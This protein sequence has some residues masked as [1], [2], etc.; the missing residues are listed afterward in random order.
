MFARSSAIAATALAA[1]LALSAPVHAQNSLRDTLQGRSYADGRRPQYPPVGRYVAAQGEGFV[2]DRSNGAPLLKFEDRQEVWAL[3]AHAGARGDIIYKNDVGQPMVRS[4]RLGGLTLFTP[5]RPIG[6]PV[7]FDRPTPPLQA[8]PLSTGQLLQTL[9]GASARASRAA[10]R[11]VPFEA[12]SVS[13]GSEPV[14]A[15]AAI[16]AA[17]GVMLAATTARGRSVL[18]RVRR[19]RFREGLAPAAVMSGDMLEIVVAPRRGLAGRPSSRRAAQALLEA[20]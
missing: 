16:L 1:G 9:A 14:V 19:V 3:Q 5:D 10:R 11:L 15:D 18:S 4:T 12:P 17:E 13:P 7:A 2:L 20:R 6:T 8:R